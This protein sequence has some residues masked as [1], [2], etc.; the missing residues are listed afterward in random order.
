M[1]KFILLLLVLWMTA[2]KA[3][4]KDATQLIGLRTLDQARTWEAVGRVNLIGTGFCTGAL[5]APDLVLTAAHCMYDKRTGERIAIE[6]VE[7]LAG[8]RNGGAVAERFAK[9]VVI[10][11]NYR[12][13]AT[14]RL[15]RVA[16]DIALIEL[17]QPIHS[18]DVVPFGRARR[19]SVGQNVEVV[20]YSKER[21]DIPSLQE[22]C[23]VLGRDPDVLVLS[24]K[25]TFGASGSPIFVMENGV[26]RIASVVSAKA[27]WKNRDVAL[28][29]S[30]GRP[31]QELISRLDA[32]GS[33][34][35]QIE[36]VSS[37]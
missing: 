22:T 18:S 6:K 26:P 9:R 24:C 32:T 36:S 30:L 14:S 2:D 31:L 13:L 16:S 27:E 4:A 1:R 20:S 10:H 8:W 28:G 3:P 23:R 12:Y 5:I 19:P 29:T 25:V 15:E 21:A 11:R 17:K 7:F 37:D 34:F 35:S 33:P